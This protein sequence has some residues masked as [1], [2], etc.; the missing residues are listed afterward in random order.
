M[1]ADVTWKMPKPATHAS[2]RMIARKSSMN[3]PLD[4]AKTPDVACDATECPSG[5][6]LQR[7]HG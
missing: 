1:A 4:R 6:D 3:P 2:A 5:D 7:S